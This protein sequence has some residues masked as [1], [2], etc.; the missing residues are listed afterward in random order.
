M[1]TIAFPVSDAHADGETVVVTMPPG[2]IALDALPAERT[3]CSEDAAEPFV[4]IGG[5]GPVVY[6]R[7]VADV[8]KQTPVTLAQLCAAIDRVAERFPPASDYATLSK[9]AQ[10]HVLAE[11]RFDALRSM[12]TFAPYV[13]VNYAG[14]VACAVRACA[15]L[16]PEHVFVFVDADADCGEHAPARATNGTWYPSLVHVGPRS[17]ERDFALTGQQF[18]NTASELAA[19]IHPSAHPVIQHPPGTAVC[20]GDLPAAERS[21]DPSILL[22]RAIPYERNVDVYGCHVVELTVAEH[23]ARV[24]PADV[25]ETPDTDEDIRAEEE[26]YT[27]G[28]RSIDDDLEEDMQSM[29]EWLET[30]F[31]RMVLPTPTPATKRARD[32]AEEET[33]AKEARTDV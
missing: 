21:L 1:A 13:V 27:K 5:T 12:L 30:A 26:D 6:R 25:D 23:A 9:F 22:R 10:H 3:W 19:L 4:Y 33:D 15:R 2:V 31:A 18:R 11:V 17:Y 28:G 8:S 7:H 24:D 29:T 16:R 32:A 14:C 20:T